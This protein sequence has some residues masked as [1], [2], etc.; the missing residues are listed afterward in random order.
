M[1]GL[2]WICE[3]ET[4]FFVPLDG[5]LFVKSKSDCLKADVRAFNVRIPN[6]RFNDNADTSVCLHYKTL[7]KCSSFRSCSYNVTRHLTLSNGVSSSLRRCKACPL[8]SGIISGNKWE[9]ASTRRR[10][11][12]ELFSFTT[13]PDCKKRE[14]LTRL[15]AQAINLVCFGLFRLTRKQKKIKN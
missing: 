10:S 13:I 14:K 5:V 7:W 6:S 3:Y 2:L 8:D 9:A 12:E 11:G 4:T 15:L 1:N